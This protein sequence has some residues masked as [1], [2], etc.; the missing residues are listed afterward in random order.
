MMRGRLVAQL[1]A[2]SWR[3]SPPAPEDAAPG[4]AEGDLAEVAPLLLKSGGAALGWRQIQHSGL[5][6]TPS[7]EEL[8]QAYR[9][10]T[11]QAALKEREIARVFSFLRSEGLDPL[12]G[13]GWVIARHYPEPGLRP[14]GDIDLYVR[15]EQH[16]AFV[17]A[18]GKPE[19]Q[20]CA[21]DLHWGA[22]ELDDRGFDELYARSQL[23]PVNGVEVRIFGPEDNFRLLCL[24]M[25]REGVLRPLWLCDIAVALSALPP[26]FDWDY[27]MRVDSQ[28][29]DWVACAIGLAHQ[30]LGADVNGMPVEQR[31]KSLPAW[32]APT[33]LEQWG[34]GRITNGRRQPMAYYLRHPAGLI[35][36]LR[37]RWPNAIEATINVKGPFNQ[38]PRL[39]FQIGSCVMRTARFV[40]QIP[41]LIV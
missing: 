8:H 26:D 34:S 41:K 24:H 10:H 30:V 15:P 40:W 35:E 28:R 11:L 33:V 13:K 17:S 16:D 3:S 20:G 6:S 36:A 31:A 29:S 12:M 7:A 21:V 38:W 39:P 25:L 23:V 32:L 18:L 19:A 27:F 2:G 22:A 5:R 14:Y 9:L 4:I 37:L 1:L